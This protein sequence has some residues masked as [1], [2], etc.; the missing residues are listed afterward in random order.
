MPC[1]IFWTTEWTIFN[2]ISFNSSKN[3]KSFEFLVA[4][5]DQSEWM[6]RIYFK[7]MICAFIATA[8]MGCASVMFCSIVKDE[9]DVNHLHHEVRVMWVNQILL[10]FP[11]EFMKWNRKWMI[12]LFS[13]PWDHR[14]PLGYFGELLIGKIMG[15]SNML[16]NGS[17]LLLFIS[18]CWHH[19]AFSQIF[20]HSVQNW[21]ISD[22]NRN[23]AQI[24]CDLIRFH[25]SGKE[26]VQ[27]IEA[28]NNIFAF[29]NRMRWFLWIWC[30]KKIK[31]LTTIL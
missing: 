9:F 18:I 19:Q 12:F 24:L 6:W 2:E 3:E 15:K 27:K 23:D 20:R 17:M 28:K 21:S 30:F 1:R 5:N 22:K 16:A 11:S 4:A 10:N 29:L 25:I 7:C 26:W 31:R 13:L 8:G 14:T